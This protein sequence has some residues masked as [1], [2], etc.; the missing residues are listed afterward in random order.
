MYP[1]GDG[2]SR[3]AV[4][5]QGRSAWLTQAQMAELFQTTKQNISLHIRNV[6]DDGELEESATVKEYLT[7]QNE[8]SR[9]V[10]RS[11]SHYSLEMILAVGYR[12][13]SQR[14]TQFRQWATTTLSEYLGKG[15]V[16][17][18]DRLKEVRTLPG[19]DY[20]DELL[21]RVR[22][23]R[24]SERR[25]YQK[26]TDIY[27]TSIDYDPNAEQTQTFFAAVQNKL[28]GA[29]H[30]QT[31]AEVVIKRADA[32]KPNLGLT[33]WKNAPGGP[34][35][36]DDA[37]VAKNYLTQD[38]ITALNR[39][40]TMYLDYAEDQ[41]RRMVP[42]PMSAWAAK[43]DAFLRFNDREVLGD[44]GSVSRELAEEH[45]GR[46]YEKFRQARLEREAREPSSD[47]DRLVER[48]KKDLPGSA[49]SSG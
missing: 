38:E 7:V 21:E 18:D 20:F 17:D 24:A 49:G 26:I 44:A 6:L 46:E 10:E 1:L 47:F 19:A 36:R 31:A 22:D 34:I 45:A 14:G 5:L 28:H 39:I 2:S 48:S 41:A 3:L 13:R 16:L 40:V 12:V 25:F 42:M 11:V 30:G 15:F 8:G 37:A 4:R 33:T 43:L 29:V 27:A 32:A 23:I 35:R 9:R